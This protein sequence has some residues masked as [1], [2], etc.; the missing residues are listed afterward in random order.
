MRA[1]IVGLLGSVVLGALAG[2]AG[3]QIV[4]YRITEVDCEE[5][6]E[7]PLGV[8]RATWI[9]SADD[10]SIVDR[11]FWWQPTAVDTVRTPTFP[12]PGLRLGYAMAEDGGFGAFDSVRFLHVRSFRSDGKKAV[13]DSD[14]RRRVSVGAEK[15]GT[16]RLDSEDGRKAEAD[17]IRRLKAG[18]PPSVKVEVVSQAGA[19]LAGATFELTADPAKISEV[20]RQAKRQ[21]D[22]RVAVYQQQ[23]RAKGDKEPPLLCPD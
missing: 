2:S 17:L 7:S 8:V 4:T 16:Y 6:V 20:A 13:P 14:V 22:K 18:K 5:V 15:I 21:G 10:G 1:A 12:A 19:T 23:I 3:A 9:L 11:T